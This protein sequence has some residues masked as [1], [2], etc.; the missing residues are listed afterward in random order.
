MQDHQY[1]RRLLR[2]HREHIRLFTD[3]TMH[4]MDAPGIMPAGSMLADAVFDGDED[5]VVSTPSFVE[6]GTC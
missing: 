6:R 4:Q 1:V 3:Q 5:L 2:L